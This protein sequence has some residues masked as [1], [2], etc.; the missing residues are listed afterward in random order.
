M[1][2]VGVDL[3]AA[4]DAGRLLWIAEG[5]EAGESLAVTSLRPA[6]ELP[7]GGVGRAEAFAALRCHLAGLG[8]ATVGLDA[9]NAL[10]RPLARAPWDAWLH[11]IA[12]RHRDAGEFRAA[13]QAAAGGREFRGASAALAKVPFAA[14]NLR[15]YRQ[16]WHSLADL[17]A[18]LVAAG[19][20]TVAP[21]Q[22][23]R[24]G[25]PRLAEICPAATL[26]HLGLYGGYK[27]RGAGPAA[28][29]AEILARMIEL[30]P[31]ILPP[32]LRERALADPGAD[33]LDAV[34]ALAAA[35][36]CAPQIAAH[37]PASDGRVF[38]WR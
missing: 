1:I 18:P 22:A 38:V 35:W 26:K 5:C 32:A 13:C 9:P 7:G 34:V 14:W 6:R 11:A 21:F 33:A 31:L 17:H 23:P 24:A 4:R 10:P 2:F 25:K 27:G 30:T 16:T 37:D 3:S 15:L 8:E 28:R 20:V 12:A 36:R 29:R 19:A